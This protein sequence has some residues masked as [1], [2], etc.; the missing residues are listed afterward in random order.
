MRFVVIALLMLFVCA[1]ALAMDRDGAKALALKTWGVNGR[2]GELP[3]YIPDRAVWGTRYC[4]GPQEYQP[5]VARQPWTTVALPNPY[6]GQPFMV[7]GK[8]QP[9]WLGCGPDWESAFVA[10]KVAVSLYAFP[11][12][13]AGAVGRGWPH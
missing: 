4:V 1:N 10:A 7:N 8:E 13:H 5:V 3:I 11:N 6:A 12:F 2:I 9:T